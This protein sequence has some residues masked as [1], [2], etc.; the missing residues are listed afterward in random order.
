MENNYTCCKAPSF[1]LKRFGEA[2]IKKILLS[3]ALLLVLF[4]F[5]SRVYEDVSLGSVA[6]PGANI[7]QGSNSNVVYVT[8]MAVAT[9]PVV[10]D[11]IQFTLSGTHDVN[12]LET[13][14]VYLNPASP[15]LPEA[16]SR[17]LR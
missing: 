8:E 3:A 7:N 13:V 10:V 16:V 9:E 1:Y 2:C 11:N 14:L 5:S 15:Y 17:V 4:S 12:D 6:M